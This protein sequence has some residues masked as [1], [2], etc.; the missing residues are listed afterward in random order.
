MIYGHI[1]TVFECNIFQSCIKQRGCRSA[2]YNTE[3]LD[4]KLFRTDRRLSPESYKDVSIAI[5]Y[6]EDQCVPG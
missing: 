5:E 4:C 2:E 1:L 3:T 6:L